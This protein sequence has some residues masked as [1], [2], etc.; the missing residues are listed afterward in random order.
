VREFAPE[1]AERVSR[2]IVW[3]LR[4][5]LIRDYSSAA[6]EAMVPFYAPA[7]L[8]EKSKD[9]L[10]IVCLRGD[11]LV[12]TASLDGDRIRNVFV[13]IDM[14]GRGIGSLL[15]AHVEAQAGAHDLTCICLHASPGAQGFYRRLGYEVTERIERELDGIPAPLIRME[16]DL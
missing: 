5:V 12:G 3:N 8:I 11:D 6:I 14:H 10:M 4:C 9:H 2:L 15:M 1:D 16:K 7:S 13:D